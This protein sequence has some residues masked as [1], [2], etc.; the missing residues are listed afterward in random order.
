VR[1]PEP[2]PLAKDRL[3]EVASRYLIARC[4]A[5]ET[6]HKPFEPTMRL[7]VREPETFVER[8]DWRIQ[9][10][11]DMNEYEPPWE[12]KRDLAERAPQAKLRDL[13]RPELQIPWVAREMLVEPRDSAGL[14]AIAEMKAMLVREALPEA[15]VSLVAMREEAERRRALHAEHWKPLKPDPDPDPAT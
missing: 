5:W 7:Y 10:I 1:L 9:G 11:F 13:Y 4:F 15:T 3:E 8:T 14:E 12:L 6:A 2:E